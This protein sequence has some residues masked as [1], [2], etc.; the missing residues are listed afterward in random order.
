MPA[1]LTAQYKCRC[2][3]HG[4]ARTQLSAAVED[5]LR[6]HI[7]GGDPDRTAVAGSILPAGARGSCR[8]DC[9]RPY[10]D[11]RSWRSAAGEVIG[12]PSRLGVRRGGI[13]VVSICRP[14]FVGGVGR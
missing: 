4:R 7:P 2:R 11:R 10:L 8:R 14:C 1:Q 12:N 13:G 6:T 5:S 9:R 3:R